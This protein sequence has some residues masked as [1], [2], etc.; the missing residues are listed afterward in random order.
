MMGSQN[1]S[2]LTLSIWESNTLERIW[3]HIRSRDWKGAKEEFKMPGITSH[4]CVDDA[5]DDKSTI[6]KHVAG[7]NSDDKYNNFRSTPS[8]AVT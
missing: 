8:R 5:T 2:I 6:N 4:L 7:S 1:G 3:V